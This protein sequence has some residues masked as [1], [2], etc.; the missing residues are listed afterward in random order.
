MLLA[1]VDR[2]A[3]ADTVAPEWVDSM[4]KLGVHSILAV[5]LSLHG[6]TLGVLGLLRHARDR[7]P[8]DQDDLAFA[9][10]VA[11]HAAVAIS[12]ASL[13]AS[14]QRELVERR[15]A[16][17]ETRTFVALVETSADFIAMAGFDGRVLFVNAAGRRLVGIAPDREVRTLSLR[18]FHTDEGLERAA[19]IRE[20]GRWQGRGV[21]RH[22]V[23]DELIPTD[24][25]SFIVR[26]AD[27]EPLCFATVQRDLRD[28]QRLEAQLRL[29]QK[30]EAIGRLAGGVAH[31]FNNLL[32]V[33]DGCIELVEGKLAD[34]GAVVA[35]E[36]AEMRSASARASALTK[37][38]LAFGRRQVLQ[39]RSVDLNAVIRAVEPVI[40]RLVAAQV[41]M[42][43]DLSPRPVP[44]RADPIQLDQVLV[45]LA[46]NA[47]DAMH[48][49]GT[50]AITTRVLDADEAIARSL[51]SRPHA[52]MFV[53]DTG[54]GMD[55]ATRERIFEPFFTTKEVGR[56]TGLGL[57]TVH[58][59][60]EQSN[61]RVRVSSELGKGTTFE[62]YLPLDDTPASDAPPSHRPTP[63]PVGVAV[64]LLAEDEDGV[65]ELCRRAL[66]SA[67]YRV[68]EA[69]DGAEAI[70]VASSF[71]GALDLLVTDMFMPVLNG[72]QL[73]DALSARR[74]GLRV[75]YM[76]GYTDDEVL[77]RGQ[78]ELG[79]AFLQKPFG[80]VAL[81]A[82]VREIL[83][84]AVDAP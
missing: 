49:G 61:G 40:R 73:H 84:L 8:F 77:R 14:L 74:P 60:I 27:G 43:F 34:N 30:M 32:M 50:L 64:I 70:S 45:N 46:V 41:H 4:R 68:L 36:L 39:P 29:A 48:D 35:R 78:V 65:R 75:L 26:A 6:R 31:D 71:E 76:S 33:V 13:L 3:F 24:V 23:T 7:A 69:R 67:G 57:A 51:P 63:K 56:G 55:A 17:Q 28:T 37:Q 44:V 10:D 21:L 1:H 79:S 20:H 16:E 54:K 58:G 15:R 25:S 11:D 52:A 22:F 53:R 81:L 2:E 83:G 66:D 5:P 59:I 42:T 72:R 80:G 38:L 19:T 12:N 47:R 18:D 82:K 9:S 62:V